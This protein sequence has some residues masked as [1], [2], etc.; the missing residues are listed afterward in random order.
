MYHEVER[1]RN[2]VMENTSQH[3]IIDEVATFLVSRPTLE[4][5]TEFNA[6]EEA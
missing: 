3:T 2:N 5:I 4:Q 6:S 1:V